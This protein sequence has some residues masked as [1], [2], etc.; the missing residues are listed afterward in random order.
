VVD[1][2]SGTPVT[3]LAPGGRYMLEEASTRR[4]LRFRPLGRGSGNIQVAGNPLTIGVAGEVHLTRIEPATILT[5]PFLAA[6]TELPS[7]T[8][9]MAPTDFPA[10]T[11]KGR[12]S[13]D[14]ELTLTPISFSGAHR[15]YL[16]ALD[17]L[18]QIIYFRRSSG[19]EQFFDFKAVDAGGQRQY[20]YLVGAP[21]DAGPGFVQARAEFMDSL[22][23]VVDQVPG[24]TLPSGERIALENHD[25]LVLGPGHFLLS[26][27]HQTTAQVPGR[28]SPAGVLASVIQEVIDGQSVFTWQS[29]DFP[30]LYMEA[31]EGNN[32][33]AVPFSDYMHFNSFE[34]DPVDGNIVASFRSQNAIFKI[35]RTDGK[36]IWKLGGRSDM[37]RLDATMIPQGQHSA[38]FNRAGQLL[39]FDNNTFCSNIGPTI[40]RFI[41]PDPVT[42][43][44]LRD[45]REDGL[46]LLQFD[47]SADRML[48]APSGKVRIANDPATVGLN[49]HSLQRAGYMGSIEELS[50]GRWLIGFGSRG[51]GEM[52]VVDVDPRTGV[53]GFELRF[54]A[55]GLPA[56]QVNTFSYRAH[57][58]AR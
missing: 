22:F 49:G 18:G 46:R 44:T 27:I 52:D 28:T 53:Q 32:F 25:F 14:G 6:G 54:N 26:G 11:T 2:Q 31:E 37:F 55:G 33:G 10:F 38:R 35:S 48:V 12:V 56:H 51:L 20:V 24:I 45:S 57:F 29:T 16:L 39:V 43:L 7:A 40:D 3:Q 15:S 8:I 21:S 36:I 13:L 58:V 17:S 9:R 19:S 23:M 1:L 41:Q 50:N 30:E 5:V 47:L 42:G 34:I 4:P